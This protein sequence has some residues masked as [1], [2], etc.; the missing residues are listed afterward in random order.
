M[1]YLPDK[2]DW[3]IFLNPD[4]KNLPSPFLLPDLTESIQTIKRHIKKKSHILLFG[5]RDT[6]GISDQTTEHIQQGPNSLKGIAGVAHVATESYFNFPMMSC[7]VMM[8]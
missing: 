1:Q 7:F 2:A 4:L 5:D 3:D 8:P 6:D